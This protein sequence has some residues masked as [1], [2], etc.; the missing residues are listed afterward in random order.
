MNAMHD[1]CQDQ[2]LFPAQLRLWQTSSLCQHFYFVVLKEVCTLVLS[3]VSR[4]HS[5]TCPSLKPVIFIYLILSIQCINWL[6]F[7]TN[8]QQPIVTVMSL[9]ALHIAQNQFSYLLSFMAV[10]QTS[11][12]S[13]V[14]IFCKDTLTSLNEP[15]V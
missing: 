12:D 2:T 10:P 3:I 13:L 11:T 5:K 4:A 9:F 6:Y 14:H 1:A 7:G 8:F 15:M